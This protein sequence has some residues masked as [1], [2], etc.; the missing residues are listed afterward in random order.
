ME[1]E[2]EIIRNHNIRGA[3]TLSYLRG[4]AEFNEG[5]KQ[6]THTVVF[7]GKQVERLRPVVELL[8]EDGRMPLTEISRRTGMPVSTVFDYLKRIKDLF[9]FSIVP[10]GVCC[11]EERVMFEVRQARMDDFIPQFKKQN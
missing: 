4:E 7:V 9:R 11:D 8:F 1:Q 10:K 3:R 5:K 2:T 6:V